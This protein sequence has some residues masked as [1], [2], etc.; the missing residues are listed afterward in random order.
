LRGATAAGV[1]SLGPRLQAAVNK[2]VEQLPPRSHVIDLA[3]LPDGNLRVVEINPGLTPQ[4]LKT[5]QDG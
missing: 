4:E 2:L 3:C 1:P 5:L